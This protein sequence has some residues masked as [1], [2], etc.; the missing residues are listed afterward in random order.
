MIEKIQA[1]EHFGKEEENPLNPFHTS[2]PF[3]AC[4][5]LEYHVMR[6]S[7]QVQTIRRNWCISYQCRSWRLKWHVLPTYQYPP[8]MLHGVTSQKAIYS[9]GIHHS[10]NIISQYFWPLEASERGSYS[11][12]QSSNA[13]RHY[14]AV[15]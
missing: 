12:K 8:N 2:P 5:P 7:I 6:Y 3:P 15:M 10:G 13:S 11:I 14:H 1:K 4:D 9:H